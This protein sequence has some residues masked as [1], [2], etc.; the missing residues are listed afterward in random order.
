M[1]TADAVA[2]LP[3]GG[4]FL[5]LW[6]RVD[7]D[8][9]AI[10]DMATKLKSTAAQAEQSGKRV[11]KTTGEV[12]DAWHGK[13]ATSFTGYMHHFGV[14]GGSVHAAMDKAAGAISGAA[15][16]VEQ[17]KSRMTA[18]ANRIMDRAEELNPLKNI[19]ETYG[20]WES[21]VTKAIQDGCAA[22]APVVQ[23]LLDALRQTSTAVHGCVQ[24]GGWVA[25]QAADSGA[26]LPKPGRPIEWNPIPHDVG[27]HS[28]TPQSSGSNG[29][30]S[31]TSGSGTMSSGTSTSSNQPPSSQPTGN[32]KQWIEQAKA[33]L[34]K[35]GVPA[36]KINEPD[37]NMIIQHESSGNPHAINLS[38]SNAA[39]GHPSTGL[40]Q[41][42]DSTFDS[43]ALSGH[44]DIWNPVDNIVAGVRYALSRY[45]S[46]DDV[47]GVAAVHGG[48]SY[49]GY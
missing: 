28:T 13:A 30:T 36:S 20:I 41:T 35:S 25:M 11:G 48:G 15:S 14:A 3:G 6:N 2:A 12:G 33:L 22:A 10:T 26:Y 44:T 43:Y 34:V 47:P 40:M 46:L 17:A 9:G 45:G 19:P 1:S 49:V 42:I 32:V 23:D 18:I 7:G 24:S 4:D 21:G 37:I 8:P 38:D 16:A 29:A 39:A 5:A 31:G 27:T